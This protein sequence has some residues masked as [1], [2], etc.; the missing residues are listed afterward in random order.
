MK[1][2]LTAVSPTLESPVDP[3]FGRGAYYITVDTETNIW[4]THPNPGIGASGGAG[5][6]AAQFVADQRAQAV[7]SGDFGP[8]AFEALDATGIEMYLFGKNETVK[9]A[10]DAFIAGKLERVGAPTGRGH[11]A[12]G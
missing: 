6:L 8:N 7:V 12:H 11:H 9:E 1:I 10:L 5:T 2:L 4:Q 3:R